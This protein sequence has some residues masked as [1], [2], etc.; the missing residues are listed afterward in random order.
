[1]GSREGGIIR[2]GRERN[3]QEKEFR[4]MAP[5]SKLPSLGLGSTANDSEIDSE[6]QDDVVE[7]IKLLAQ[8]AICTDGS[9]GIGPFTFRR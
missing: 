8:G 6:P 3:V 9:Q 4:E 2:Q 7:F 5:L 1:M